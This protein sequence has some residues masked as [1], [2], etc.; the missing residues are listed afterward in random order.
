MPVAPI[1]DVEGDIDA[2]PM[3]SG[4]GVG[5][6]KRIQPAADIVCEIDTEAKSILARLAR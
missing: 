5:L 3:W 1:N 2:L 4:Q 6:V